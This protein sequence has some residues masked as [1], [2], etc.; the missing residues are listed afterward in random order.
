MRSGPTR[1]PARL[2][3]AERASGRRITRGIGLVVASLL[4]FLTG[5]L[6]FTMLDGETMNGENSTAAPSGSATLLPPVD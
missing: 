5:A 6:L 1:K 3:S 4:A 2:Q